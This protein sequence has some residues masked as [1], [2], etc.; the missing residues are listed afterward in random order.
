MRQPLTTTKTARARKARRST[1]GSL[2][3]PPRLNLSEWAEANL[4][5]SSENSADPGRWRTYSFQR[6]IMDAITDPRVTQVTWLKSAR[7]GATSIM[8]AAIGY[9]IHQDPCPIMIVQPTL[10]DAE[11]WSRDQLTPMLQECPSL[12]GL[13]AKAK[14]R[15]SDN[16]LRRKKF[17]GGSLRIFGANSPTGFRARTIRLLVLDEVDAYPPSAGSEG[18][19]IKLGIRRTETYWNRKII[20]A[21]T[22]LTS[23]ESKIEALYRAGDMRRYYVPCPHCG[24]RDVLAFQKDDEGGGHWMTWPEGNPAAAYFV[25]S[26][27]GAGIDHSH[28]RAMV[29]AGQ[30]RAAAP[31]TGHASFF[32]W[33]AY[34]FSPNATWGQIATEYVTA[35]KDGPEQLKTFWNT[36]LGRTWTARG[37]APEW[38]RLWDRREK[39]AAGEV[40]AGVQF[41]T[42]GVDVQGDRLVYEVVGWSARKESWSIEIGNFNGSTAGEDSKVWRQLDELLAKTWRTPAG[43]ILPIRLLAIDTGF[44]TQA[45]YAWVR[46]HSPGPVMAVKGDGTDGRAIVTSYREE[47][48]NIG[49][50]KI[51]NG[52][53]LWPVGVNAAKEELYGWLRLEAPTE[54]GDPYPSGYC[55]FPEH[56]DHFFKELTAEQLVEVRKRSGHTVRMWQKL[57]GRANEHLDIRVYA[58]AAAYRLQMDMGAAWAAKSEGAPATPAKP[59]PR[60]DDALPGMPTGWLASARGGRGPWLSKRR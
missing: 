57:P 9:H 49:G 46:R 23:G 34:S 55:H 60:R 10:D 4:L 22:P 20:A 3:P 25:C 24:H 5:L 17:P 38:R 15:D 13:V 43:E 48:V 39:Y 14:S 12:R 41:L 2:R 18:D 40:P 56:G 53:Q 27:C 30:W 32:I 44:N 45:V 6:A 50:N 47:D 7:V 21:S 8:N 54:P 36:V 19:P 33:A 26:G 1:A 11:A 52:V 29:D 28:K 58:R 35:E 59:A 16:S 51:P 31:F 42:A 37:D